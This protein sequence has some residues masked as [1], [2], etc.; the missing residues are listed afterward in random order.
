M[1]EYVIAGVAYD[2]SNFGFA[3]FNYMRVG[4]MFHPPCGAFTDNHPE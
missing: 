1:T 4:I 2:K 3:I